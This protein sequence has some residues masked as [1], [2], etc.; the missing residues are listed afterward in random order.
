MGRG[1][2]WSPGIE[3][4][5]LPIAPSR[6][7]EW[8]MRTILWEGDHVR[9]EEDAAKKVVLVIR[10]ATRVESPEELEAAYLASMRRLRPEHRE[11]GLVLDGRAALGRN[12][13][14]FEKKMNAMRERVEQHVG[15]IVFL[16]ATATGELQMRRMAREGGRDPGPIAHDLDEAIRLAS[17][18]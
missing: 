3:L 1:S 4:E 2:S 10:K 9:V 13:P 12:E 16:V 18:L 11:F 8:L 17:P 15:K 6:P 7:H 5:P 14:E